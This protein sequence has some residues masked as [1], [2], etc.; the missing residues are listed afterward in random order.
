[1]RFSCRGRAHAEIGGAR[2]EE[3]FS[4]CASLTVPQPGM[5]PVIDKRAKQ[6]P[7]RHPLL[8]DRPTWRCS[9]CSAFIGSVVAAALLLSLWAFC[10]AFPLTSSLDL[11]L[12]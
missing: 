4:S 3:R 2:G 7:A 1:M 10:A 6:R 11:D 9:G 8:A 12:S 5:D